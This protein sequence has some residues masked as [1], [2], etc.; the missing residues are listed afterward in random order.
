MEYW[1]ISAPGEKTCQQTWESLQNVTAKQGDL[2]TNWKFHIPDLK[3]GTLDLLVGLSED[4]GKLDS[5]VEQVMKKVSNYLGDVLEDQRDKLSENLLANGVDLAT[6]ITRF[7][8]DMAKYP[9]KQSLK[10][11]SDI[12]SK[13]VSQIESDLKIKS[14]TYNNLKSNL[15]NIERKQTGSL[16]TRN[17][18]DLVKKEQFVH[19][20]EYLTTLLVVVPKMHYQDWHN[21]Y[22]RLTDMIVPRSTQLVFEDND[23]GLFT[24]SLFKKVVDEF[25]QKA[26]ENRFVVRDF[27]YNEEELAAGNN[28]YFKLASEKKKQLG[29]LVRWL[30]VNFGETFTAWI[31]IKALRVFVESVLRYGLPV[32]F[33]AML[34][35]PQKKNHKRLREVLNQQY[36]HLD[37]TA[38]SGDKHDVMD[39]PGLGFGTGEYYPYVYFKIN[40][41]M[42]ER[43]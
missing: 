7:Q 5:F 43:I 30:K 12:I 40:I 10:N 2:S 33:Q 35:H 8:W 6:Y 32:N 22:E 42:V 34:L 36:A 1:L 14:N 23:H 9:T 20:S 4:L 28:E 26:R 38:S 41:D 39:M 25:K 24:V 31:H 3:V 13:Q 18:G 16:L 19:N 15:Q 21:K 17:V 29:P 27:T 11:I 37:S